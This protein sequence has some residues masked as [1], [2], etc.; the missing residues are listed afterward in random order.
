MNSHRWITE[1]ETMILRTKRQL[2]AALFFAWLTALLAL[3]YWPN[4]PEVEI[5]KE[6]FRTDYLGHFG[7]YALLLLFY[8]LWQKAR[9]GKVTAAFIL[10]SAMAGVVLGGLTEV[11]QHLVPGRSLNPLDLMFNCLG[12]VAG[13]VAF[14]V[15]IGIRGEDGRTIGR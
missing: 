1:T 15:F 3:T 7:F 14:A 6:W 10:Q 13:A 2:L 8:L 12:I 11:S 9:R 5:K 4:M